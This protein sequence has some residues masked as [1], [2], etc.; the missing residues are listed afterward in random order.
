MSILTIL[1][2]TAPVLR[3]NCNVIENIDGKLATL[4]QDMIET[5][6]NASGGGLAANQV[7]VLNR[8]IVV[9]LAIKTEKKDPIVII[10]PEI[11]AMEEEAIAEEGCLSIPD[12]FAE[13]KRSKKIELKGVDINGKDIRIE[14]EDFLARVLQHELDHLNGIL[15]WDKL[16]KVKRDVLKRKF[17]KLLKEAAYQ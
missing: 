2:C 8:L 4:A 17:K 16:G 3:K 11:T 12:L 7:G 6:F 14:A 9:D 1:N 15:F 13:V 5:M 10:N